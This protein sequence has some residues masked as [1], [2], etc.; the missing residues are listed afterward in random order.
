MITLVV[1]GSGGSELTYRL[2]KSVVSIGASSTN[3]VVIRAPGVAPRHLVVQRSGEAVTFLGQNRQV[4]VLNGERRSRGVVRVG[5]RVR[6]GTVTVTVKEIG[7]GPEAGVLGNADAGRPQVKSEEPAVGQTRTRSEI[8][9]FTEPNRL[10]SARDHMVEMFVDGVRSDIGP[11]LESFFQ[12]FFA[13]KR[14]MLARVD[15][16]GRFEPLVAVWDADPLRL[17]PRTF[18]ELQREG[19]F[20]HLRLGAKVFIIFPVEGRPEEIS[21]YLVAETVNEDEDEVV[22]AEL[23][24]LLTIHW[25]RVERSERLLG[26]WETATAKLLGEQLPGSSPG[27]RTLRD[28]ALRA[29]ASVFPVMVCGRPGSGRATTA[30][31]IARL[32]PTAELAVTAISCRAGGDAAFR[33]TLFGV[34][35]GGD[36]ADVV[37]RFP[38][39]S[40]VVIRDIHLLSPELQEELAGVIGRDM[41]RPYGPAVRWM[42]T[43]TDRVADLVKDNLVAPSLFPM[44]HRHLLFIPAFEDRREDLALLV[45]SLVE[46]MAAEQGR[47]VSGIELETLGA[48]LAH[49]FDGQIGELVGELRRL[50]A[51]TLKGEILRGSVPAILRSGAMVGEAELSDTSMVGLLT[52]DDLKA[53]I[54]AVEQMIIDR[55][56]RRCTGNQS[57]AARELN[58]SR[59][60][61]IAKMKEYDI[62]DYRFLR[63]RR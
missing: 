57:R 8:V 31:L 35:E 59:G 58:L 12:T 46:A 20:A 5:D 44:F 24:R 50:V 49:P 27:I 14:A 32:N 36:L 33:V 37:A 38:R 28:G 41:D 22:L 53:V 51:G 40:A 54:P 52:H 39:A 34:A 26:Q 13:G 17:P 47:E 56:L 10:A 11:S 60:A 18:T 29:A 43:T 4:V 6:I 55:V 15:G 48:I 63:R 25:P 30:A 2:T 23:A 3:D 7:G 9:L 45:V 61:L 42:A 19:R 21:A 62:P 1:E 16:E